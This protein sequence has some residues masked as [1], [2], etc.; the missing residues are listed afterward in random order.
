MIHESE[1]WRIK[2]NLSLKK[3]IQMAEKVYL[4]PQIQSPSDHA[5]F[6]VARRSFDEM[7]N[8]CG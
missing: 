6:S 2:I 5:N 7:C 3:T 8:A 4:L 1:I